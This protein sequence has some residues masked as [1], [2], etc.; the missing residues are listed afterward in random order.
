MF[1]GFT[2]KWEEFYEKQEEG[3]HWGGGGQSKKIL[4]KFPQNT[5]H[6]RLD[7][8]LEVHSVVDPERQ[9]GRRGFPLLKWAKLF[10]ENGKYFYQNC[11]TY[12]QREKKSNNSEFLLDQNGKLDPPLVSFLKTLRGYITLI[13][14][15]QRI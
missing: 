9:E 13:V 4:G 2:W 14:F 8:G 12:D 7:Y 15:F 1:F 11:S 6:S 5:W 10:K 3:F